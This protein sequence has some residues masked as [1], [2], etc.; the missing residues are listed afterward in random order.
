MANETKVGLTAF[1]VLLGVFGYVLYGKYEHR[2]VELAAAA[3][4]GDTSDADSPADGGDP[5]DRR[6]AADDLADAGDPADADDPAVAGTFGD[7]GEEPVAVAPAA[8][9]AFGGEPADE[10]FLAADD[11]AEDPAAAVDFGDDGGWGDFAD[12]APADALATVAVVGAGTEPA[13]DADFFGA[14]ATAE[15][16]PVDSAGLTAAAAGTDAD[17]GADAGGFWGEDE[18]AADAATLTAADPAD[19]AAWGLPAETAGA[20]DAFAAAAATFG[21]DLAADGLGGGGFD[22]DPAADADEPVA[23]ADDFGDE[24]FGDAAGTLAGTVEAM[25]DSN[26]AFANAYAVVS[27]DAGGDPFG[28]GAAE[29]EL[30]GADGLPAETIAANAA[31]AGGAFGSEPPDTAP[32]EAT[33]FWG[34]VAADD[35]EPTTLADADADAGGDGEAWGFGE[36]PGSGEPAAGVAADH[37]AGD[38]PSE[39]TVVT[40]A[41]SPE[42]PAGAAFDWDRPPAGPVLDEHA[43]TVAAADMT[44][45]GPFGAEPVLPEPQLPPAQA[46]PLD[47]PPPTAPPAFA[48][49]EPPVAGRPA[50]TRDESVRPA[51][52][53]VPARFTWAGPDDR[54]VATVLPGETYWAIAKR[55]YGDVKYF[56]A[57]ARYNARRIP[58]PRKLAPGMKI[59]CPAPAVLRPYDPD[60]LAGAARPDRPEPAAGRGYGFDE[61]GRPVFVVGPNDTLGGIAQATLGK[62]SRWRQLYALNRDKIAD[63]NRLKP[64]TLLDLPADAAGLRRR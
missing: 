32:A 28:D 58:D 13:A 60:L 64:G 35:P 39:A 51:A 17:A 55:C 14:P 10:V 49:A 42:P 45:G 34:D 33:P 44:A 12:D 57:L 1:T 2:L 19:D 27:P 6:S 25:P 18:E 54:K 43:G 56:K 62:A 30:F 63:P 59:V 20:A 41:R 3:T 4:A 24:N 50:A 47:A 31:P 61:R 22:H 11:P 5:A 21:D 23:L 16:V 40:H 36:E 8:D 26:D 7:F 38:G 37:A 15:V 9:P 53:V 48:A 29:P 52:A 46:P